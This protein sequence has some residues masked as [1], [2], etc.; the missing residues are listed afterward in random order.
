MLVRWMLNFL[1]IIIILLWVIRVL[2][3]NMFSGL[4]VVWF[5]F[6]IEFWLSCSRLWMLMWVWLIFIVRVIG[7][8]RIMF[9][10]MFLLLRLFS[11][12]CLVVVCVVLGVLFMMG[13]VLW[14]SCCVGVF[15][16]GLFG[17]GIV[18]FCGCW[19]GCSG[20]GKLVCFW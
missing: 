4:F 18:W 12:V 10:L 6:I 1:L 15:C 13:F 8:F 16:G 14:K 2:L 7:M 3:M 17:F 19:F 11:R 20:C 5:S 9:R